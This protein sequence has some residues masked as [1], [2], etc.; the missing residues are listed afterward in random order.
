MVLRAEIDLTLLEDTSFRD[1]STILI[2]QVYPDY[3]RMLDDLEAYTKQYLIDYEIVFISSSLA[4]LY[5]ELDEMYRKE[6]LVL[7]P[8]LVKLEQE[9]KKADSCSAFKNT[10]QH[11]TAIKHQLNQTLDY[12]KELPREEGEFD[13]VV[14]LENSLLGLDKDMT[15]LQRI[16]DE[17]YYPKFKNCINCRK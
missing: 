2:E 1:F 16:K 9:N 15:Y 10:K 17:N 3:F 8:F 7:F 6:K 5:S 12:L 14:V 13:F 4:K 11:Y